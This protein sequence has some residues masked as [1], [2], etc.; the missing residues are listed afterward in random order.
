MQYPIS[1]EN[2]G[3]P[4]LKVDGDFNE[5]FNPD[6]CKTISEFT[7]IELSKVIYF[8][9]NFGLKKF[10]SNPSLMGISGEQELLLKDLEK[11]ILFGAENSYGTNVTTKSI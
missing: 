5:S 3:Y 6:I 8:V 7:H 4:T 1:S 2:L 10:F 9:H 11:L